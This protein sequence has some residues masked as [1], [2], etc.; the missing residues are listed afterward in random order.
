MGMPAVIVLAILSDLQEF[1]QE[2][3]LDGSLCSNPLLKA[4]KIS[5]ATSLVILWVRVKTSTVDRNPYCLS[6]RRLFL[7]MSSIISMLLIEAE[8]TDDTKEVD[9]S[10]L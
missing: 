4:F 3:G 5:K 2:K 6:H 9:K 10:I 1:S 8:F 7:V